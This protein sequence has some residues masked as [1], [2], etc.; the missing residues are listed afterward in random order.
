MTTHLRA[1]ALALAVAAAPFAAAGDDAPNI[2]SPSGREKG[3]ALDLAYSIAFWGIPFGHTNY[4]G[5]FDPHGYTARSH[6]ET[7]GIVSLFWQATIDASANG[8]IARTGIE[9][10]VY[11]SFYRRGSEK[12][13]RVQVTFENG[14]VKTFADPP[15]PT[16]KF[17]VT[18][19]QKRDAF[20]PMSAITLV[21][22]GFRADAANPCGTAAPVFDG[23]R[24]YDIV[25]SFVKDEP[26]KL[27]NGL[28]RG[29]AHLCRLRYDQ[30]AGFKPKILKEGAAF[31]PIFADFA[32][33]SSPAA[34]N[35]RFVVALRLWS[36]L[37]WGTV[38]AEL[39]ALRASPADQQKS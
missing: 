2:T 32:D 15:Y 9:P 28:F 3:G 36:R 33:I 39:T 10:S 26:V 29:N 24:R 1:L 37:T 31:P 38:S 14:A 21:L 7:S 27:D 18:D 20:D 11:D 34:P 23:R 8:E 17:P 4:D 25:F 35:G 30:I 13:E 22:S 12:N 6:F 5:R 19:D 16:V